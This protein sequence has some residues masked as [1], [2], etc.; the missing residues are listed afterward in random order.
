ML[1]I[2]NV[3]FSQILNLKPELTKEDCLK[4]RKS[5][6]NDA[7][8]LLVAG[9]G[10]TVW[11]LASSDFLCPFCDAKPFPVIPVSI[12]GAMMA[13]SITLFNIAGSNK[14]KAASISL[15]N[16][17]AKLIQNSQMVLKSIP[18]LTFTA[19]F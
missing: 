1:L 16:E 7:W 19:N 13:G 8:L 12:G 2:T 15:K 17:H 4:K 10:V 14:R 5:Q 6:R 18:S 9:T 11:A 3:S